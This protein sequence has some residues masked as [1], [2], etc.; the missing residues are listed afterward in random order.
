MDQEV[1]VKFYMPMLAARFKDRGVPQEKLI[2]AVWNGVGSMVMNDGS[3]TNEDAF[4]DCFSRELSIERADVEDEVLD[5][6]GNE[7]NRA[8]P[9]SY[10]H[11]DVYKRQ[12][13]YGRRSAVLPW[14]SDRA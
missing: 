6:Y 10:T 2:G 13:L 8:I 1:F 9:V 3:R 4:W 11:L 5:F 14:E 7:F 12:A